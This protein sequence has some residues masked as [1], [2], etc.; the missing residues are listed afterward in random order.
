MGI[1]DQRR[2]VGE[3][4]LQRMLDRHGETTADKVARSMR[5]LLVITAAIEKVAQN[6]GAEE[7]RNGACKSLVIG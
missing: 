4:Y 1:I 3:E 2:G 7:E 6:Q 5:V